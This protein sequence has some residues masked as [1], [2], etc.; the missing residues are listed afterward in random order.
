MKHFPGVGLIFLLTALAAGAQPY[1][2]QVYFK[3]SKG[4]LLSDSGRVYLSQ[5]GGS[6]WQVKQLDGSAEVR[7]IHFPTDQVGY[8]VGT[9]TLLKTADGGAHSGR[10]SCA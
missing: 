9:T 6:S 1:Y 7:G 5:D 2:P 10:T 3:G 4:F 8:L